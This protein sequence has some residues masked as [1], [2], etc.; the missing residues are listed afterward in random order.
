MAA[1]LTCATMLPKPGP[2]NIVFFLIIDRALPPPFP[3]RTPIPFPLPRPITSCHLPSIGGGGSS[4]FA[5]LGASDSTN[6]TIHHCCE[7]F[8]LCKQECACPTHNIKAID[9]LLLAGSTLSFSGCKTPC[10]RNFVGI[11][12]RNNRC[13]PKCRP[14]QPV[15]MHK[16]HLPSC[17]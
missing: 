11:N 17:A 3:Q 9:E 1:S 4:V 16:Y 14:T 5:D 15:P 12:R 13:D 8:P 10:G 7:H 6:R 2:T